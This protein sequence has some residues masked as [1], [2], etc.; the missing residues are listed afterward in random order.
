MVSG[1][2]QGEILSACERAWA[3]LELPAEDCARRIEDT[4]HSDVAARWQLQALPFVRHRLMHEAGIHPNDNA[5]R[6]A[7]SDSVATGQ[8]SAAEL[9][10][11]RH[12]NATLAIDRL[13]T[14]RFPDAVLP[15]AS[16][17]G[18][19]EALLGRTPALTE[20][21]H[22]CD[23][24]RATPQGLA[25]LQ[26]AI[27]VFDAAGSQ[28]QGDIAR[29][30]AWW[31][32]LAWWAAGRAALELG[33]QGA[34]RQ[35][36]EH[37]VAHYTQAA[38]TQA[39]EDCRER[40]RDLA[41]RRTGDFDTAAGRELSALLLRRDPLGR[42]RALCRLVRETLATGDRF[43][44]ARLAEQAALVLAEAGYPDPESDFD[45]AAQQWVDSACPTCTGSALIAQLCEIAQHWAAI[46]G[47]RA[48]Q[49][50]QDDPAASEHAELVL[51]R[52]SPWAGELL[53][54]A[55][56]AEQATAQRFAL[57]C[58]PQTQPL[59]ERHPAA[60]LPQGMAALS[61]LDDVLVELRAACNE[62]ADPSQ[63]DE[64]R[65]LRASALKA[66]SRIHVTRAW[67]E[68]AYVLLAL[69]RP[70]EAAEASRQALDGLLAGARP[71][72]SAFATG[73]ERE[74]Y[75]TAISYQA[76]AL[77]AAQDHAAI[78]ALCEP[79]IRDLEGERLRVS[80]PYQQSAF[81][82][83]R[84]ELYEAVAAAAY[85]AGQLDLLLETTE[86]LK[87]R[88]ALRNRLAPDMPLD[89]TDV[90]AELRRVHAALEAAAPGSQEEHSLRERRHWLFST[91]SIQR[92]R[93]GNAMPQVSVASLQSHLGADEAAISWFWIG[94][95]AL[96]VLGV[97]SDRTIHTVIKL[98]GEQQARLADYIDCMHALAEP[99]P[100]YAV[101]IPKL[102]ALIGEL[103]P[104]LLPP[105]L[106]PVIAGKARLVLCPHRTLH[107]FAFHAVALNG[108]HLGVTHA[109]RYTPSL[110]NLLV[111]WHG[112]T[113]GE[114]LAVGVARFD[115]P[116]LPDLPHAEDEAIT[117]AALHGPQGHALTT[118]SRAQFLSA[119]LESL[120]CLHLATHGSSVLAGAAV[121]DPLA[122]GMHLRD[123]MLSGWD[124]LDLRLPAEVVV[125]ATCHS[126][127]R[128]IAGRGLEQLPGDDLFGL[129]AMLCQAGV[130]HLLGALWRV[131]DGAAST[132]VRDFHRAYASGATPDTALR[133]AIRSYLADTTQRHEAFFWAPFTLT[134]F[135]R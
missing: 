94:T 9:E 33:Q 133:E 39:A 134:T 37:A 1:T 74:L 116:V 127:Q 60:P 83:T 118:A 132:I 8:A 58:P 67:L 123:G 53:N 87:A 130:H 43:E 23:V 44:A 38:D 57:W 59:P 32:G 21:M 122:C 42:A 63:I 65:A 135:G 114:V 18:Q 110:S 105:V 97:S 10:L 12:L 99:Q 98:N 48:S 5:P 81:L 41:A 78:I 126:A 28:A 14:E 131:D 113:Q 4:I 15:P 35:A 19:R 92:A 89:A 7:L 72:L 109:I 20:A 102:D 17:D 76:R 26:A 129:P 112:N 31:L 88:S 120:R 103:G 50:M 75:L 124:L 70:A 3:W 24:A 62:G 34:G 51:R 86:L 16:S 100:R 64:A 96:I 108:N 66:G 80:S 45:K 47:A 115:D 119:P 46:L 85:N 22:A 36:Y 11:S 107:L 61:L 25:R 27:A 73:F 111:P 49:R 6:A 68:E 106:H 69:Q 13:V 121:D 101:L 79:V 71:A 93:S 40:L 52:I 56:A 128:A 77:M 91:R 95:A 82:A 55:D 84:T 2:M 104:L 54:Q 30:Q 117:I 29:E 125:L 90:D